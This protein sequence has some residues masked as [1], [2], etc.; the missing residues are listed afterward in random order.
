MVNHDLCEP[1]QTAPIGA[2]IKQWTLRVDNNSHHHGVVRIDESPLYLEL[3]YRLTATSPVKRVGLFRLNLPG[4]L[5]D[6]YI[7]FEPANASGP[8][9]RLRII[10]SVDG[11]F[12]IQVNQK[13]PSLQMK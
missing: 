4:L 10:R 1:V 5:R 7:R 6:G 12:F 3:S 8:E 9:L 11:V 2:K 13:S